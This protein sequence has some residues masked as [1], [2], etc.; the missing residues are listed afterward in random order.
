MDFSFEFYEKM[1]RDLTEKAWLKA[2]EI[3]KI[4][5]MRPATEWSRIVHDI[6]KDPK[7][8]AGYDSVI[9]TWFNRNLFFK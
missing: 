3:S 1:Q 5:E 6:C 9:E 2:F 7:Q 8:N 4:L